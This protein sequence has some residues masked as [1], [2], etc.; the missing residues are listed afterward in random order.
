MR[1]VALHTSNP[2]INALIQHVPVTCFMTTSRHLTV[3]TYKPCRF[4][5]LRKKLFNPLT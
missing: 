3:F 4:S 5:M 2:L 1:R